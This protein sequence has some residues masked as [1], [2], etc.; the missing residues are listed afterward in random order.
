MTDVAARGIDI[1][2]LNNVINF[3]WPP[4][5]KLFIHRSGR[6]ARAGQKGTTYSFLNMDELPYLVEAQVFIGRKMIGEA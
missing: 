3:D 6:T 4:A 1:P 5:M 2:F